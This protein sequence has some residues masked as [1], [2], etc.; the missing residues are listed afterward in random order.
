M[1][2]H[3]NTRQQKQASVL[4]SVKQCLALWKAGQCTDEFKHQV[5]FYHSYCS[6]SC[7]TESMT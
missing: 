5:F 2:N 4:L 1:G 3:L 7:S 6:M